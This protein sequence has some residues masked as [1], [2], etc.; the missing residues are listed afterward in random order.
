M[1]QF[2]KK[3]LEFCQTNIITRQCN[4]EEAFEIVNDLKSKNK[5]L[6][7]KNHSESNSNNQ[8]NPAVQLEIKLGIIYLF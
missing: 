2:C 3:L 1:K 5:R 7:L 6:K 8:M 4:L